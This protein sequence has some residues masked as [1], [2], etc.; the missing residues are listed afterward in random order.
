MREH[1]RHELLTALSSG[2]N[3]EELSFIA[4]KFDAIAEGY[5]IVRAETSLAVVGRDELVGLIKTYLVVKRMEGLSEKTLDQYGIYLH[6][7]MLA[8]NKAPAEITANDIRLFLYRYQEAKGISNRTLDRVR[9]VVCSFFRWAASEEYIPRS[10]VE[11]I[12]AIKYEEKPR[13]AISQIELERIRRACETP[14]ELAIIE[15]LYSTGCRVSELIGIKLIDVDWSTKSVHLLGKGKKHRESYINAK[16]E[17]AIREYLADRKHESIYLLCNDRG[18]GPM[19]K[20]NVERMMR[21]ISE[22]AGFMDRRITPHVMRHT[23]ATQAVR[24]GMA[25]EDVQRLLGH[26]NISTTMIYAEVSQDGVQSMHRKCV[27]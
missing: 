9:S 10:P 20:E 19:K 11:T 18:G 23:T 4:S 21:K 1:M 7:M 24:S 17:I 13:H 3:T 6:K 25:V 15:T 2:M 12:K 27:V 16:A 14:R 22:R 5:E 26:S 8:M